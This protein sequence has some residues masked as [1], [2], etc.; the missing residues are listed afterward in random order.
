MLAGEHSLLW[1]Q[2]WWD[3]HTWRAPSGNTINDIHDLSGANIDHFLMMSRIC[4]SLIITPRSWLGRQHVLSKCITFYG[5]NPTSACIPACKLRLGIAMHKRTT[6]F[7]EQ[8]ERFHLPF[9]ATSCNL[10]PLR[11]SPLEIILSFQ[12]AHSVPILVSRPCIRDFD[13]H[14]WIRGLRAMNHDRVG[15]V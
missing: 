9:V 2:T 7:V 10:L 8:R 3:K 1:G 15:S 6:L 12:D 4:R 11:Y 14:G 13:G 5:E